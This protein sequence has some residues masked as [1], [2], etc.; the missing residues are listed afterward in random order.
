MKYNFKIFLTVL[1]MAAFLSCN[2]G[3]GS[4]QREVNFDRDASYALGLNIG[5]GLKEGL[6]ADGIYPNI[7]EF[8]KGMRDGIAGREPRFDILHARDILDTA[9][10]AMM[11]EVFAEARQKEI[12]FLAENARKPG[13][14]ITS[15]GLQYEI[16]TEGNGP[17]PKEMDT[18]VVH[19]DGKFTDGKF[20]DSSNTRG[21]PSEFELNW[22]IPG[23]AEGLQLMSV[24]SKYR[25]YIPSELGYGEE[26][27]QSI[28]PP[29]ATL[30]F[31]VELL[32]IKTES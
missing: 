16:I 4:S 13:I 23:W 24:G 20:F 14:I 2:N 27:I 11:E 30:V 21:Y 12:I 15:S 5:A 6:E 31:D 7:D 28:I 18:V 8:I 26:G 17:K 22:I 1:T 10:D 3:S 25:F 9:L 19:Y 29:F 32:E